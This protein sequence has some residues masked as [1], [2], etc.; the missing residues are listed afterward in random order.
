VDLSFDAL[1]G[2]VSYSLGSSGS[3]SVAV[4]PYDYYEKLNESEV[5]QTATQ[6]SELNFIPGETT[7]VLFKCSG[8]NPS[9]DIFFI[10]LH[11][12]IR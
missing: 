12:D 3:A 11:Q 1:T 2:T 4:H 10:L 6:P 8:F 9:E 7:V 5:Q